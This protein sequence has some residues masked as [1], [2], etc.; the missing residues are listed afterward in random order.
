LS[1]CGSDPC[2]TLCVDLAVELDACVTEWGTGWEELGADSRREWRTACQA[3]WDAQRST[4]E[5]REVPA[6]ESACDDAALELADVGC[7]E[8]RALYLSIGR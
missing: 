6:A 4:L 2:R 7:D 1:A 3:D 8:L 5:A